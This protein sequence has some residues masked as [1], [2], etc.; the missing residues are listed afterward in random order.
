MTRRTERVNELL[1]EEISRIVLRELHDPAFQRGL[2]SVTDVEVSPD[3]RHARV[4]VSVMGSEEERVQVFEA[5]ER[6]RHFVERE[7]SRRLAMRQTPELAFRRDDSIERAVRLT[8]LIKDVAAEQG[9]T[10]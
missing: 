5:L 8:Q 9:D 7:L 10:L 3:L 4:F 2:I 6:A 1:R